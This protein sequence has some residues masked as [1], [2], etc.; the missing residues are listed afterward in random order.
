MTGRPPPRADRMGG[1]VAPLRRRRRPSGPRPVDMFDPTVEVQRGDRKAGGGLLR[2]GRRVLVPVVN[3]DIP[4][5][6]SEPGA[7]CSQGS[8]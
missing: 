2:R 3:G 7:G 8:K 1:V 5:T 4:R 6:Y